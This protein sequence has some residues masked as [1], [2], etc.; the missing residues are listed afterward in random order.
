MKIA[1]FGGTFDP[2]H[3]GH[4]ALAE[5]V[6]ARRY[7]DRVLFVP[8]PVPPHKADRLITPFAIRFRMLEAALEGRNRFSLSDLENR[9][10]GRSYTIDTLKQLSQ[11]HQ[12]DDILLLIGGD[13]LRQLHL[14][15]DA[16]EIVRRFGVIAYP[17]GD[18]AVSRAELLVHWTEEE[19]EKLLASVLPSPPVFPVSSTEIRTMIRC[20]EWSGASGLLPAPVLDFIRRNKIYCKT[21]QEGDN[22]GN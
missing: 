11:F 2:V 21:T 16:H 6:L 9:R 12:N 20:G 7:A 3:N 5:T 15:K 14:W 22:D 1:V 19:T 10:P 8:A 4:I 18:H 13:S 17:R